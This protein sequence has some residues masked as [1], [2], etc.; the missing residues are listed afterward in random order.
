MSR[1][2]CRIP[3][4][5]PVIFLTGATGSHRIVV[6]SHEPTMYRIFLILGLLIVLYFLL[7]SAYRGFQGRAEGRG[8]PADQ[9]RMVQDP[10]CGV[11]V[12]RGSA[13]EETIEGTTHYFCSPDCAAA[14]RAGTRS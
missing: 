9:G 6:R 4:I 11:F 10:A 13:V 7:R 12:P 2:G 8:T 5:A 3:V 1:S 14:F